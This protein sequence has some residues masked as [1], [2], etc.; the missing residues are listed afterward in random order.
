MLTFHLCQIHL[1]SSG[2]SHNK[3]N[4]T[5]KKVKAEEEESNKL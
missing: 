2:F 5:T 1:L 4:N 3:K